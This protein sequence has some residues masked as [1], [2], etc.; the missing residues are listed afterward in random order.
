MKTCYFCGLM[1][2][3]DLAV[4]FEFRRIDTATQKYYLEEWAHEDCLREARRALWLLRA[5]RIPQ[6]NLASGPQKPE[7]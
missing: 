2:F 6:S 4:R 7:A 3:A 1:A 5:Q